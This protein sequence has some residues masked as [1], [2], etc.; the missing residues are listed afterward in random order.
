M[1]DGARTDAAAFVRGFGPVAE[2][3]L[4]RLYP[5]PREHGDGM[6]VLGEF[7]WLAPRV[8]LLDPATGRVYSHLGDSELLAG[9]LD[10]FGRL[11]GEVRALR[12]HAGGPW[13]PERAARAAL[14]RVREYEPGVLTSDPDVC[15]FWRAALLVWPLLHAPGP[16]RGGLRLGLTHERLATDLGP[17]RVVRIPSGN[18]P[19][20]LDSH[21]PSR[22]FL[23]DVGLVDAPPVRPDPDRPLSVAAL[24]AFDPHG[25]RDPPNAARLVRLGGVDVVGSRVDLLLDADDGRVHGWYRDDEP[26]LFPIAADLSTL[27]FAQWLIARVRAYDREFAITHDYDGLAAILTAVLGTVDPIAVRGPAAYWPNVFD[28]EAG[29]LLYG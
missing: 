3:A 7:G 20:V 23:R 2:A 10:T 4:L 29:G 8:I 22:R 1:R 14:G 28:D 24:D 19:D 25:Y 16:G 18:I 9:G 27:A 6:L 26:E 12:A 13:D 15:A 11:L 17:E 5:E 21:A